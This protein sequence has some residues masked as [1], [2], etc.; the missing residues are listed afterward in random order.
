MFDTELDMVT[1]ETDKAFQTLDWQSWLVNGNVEA[2]WTKNSEAKTESGD[3]YCRKKQL[4]NLFKK[5]NTS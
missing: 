1:A 4:Y 5:L 3:F 2:A